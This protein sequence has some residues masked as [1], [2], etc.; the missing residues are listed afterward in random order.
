MNP[1]LR[2]L[3]KLAV[4]SLFVACKSSNPE[5]PSQPGDVQ[6]AMQAPPSGTTGAS[7]TE[8]G[9]TTSGTATPAPTDAQTTSSSAP[10]AT[11]MTDAE[12]AAIASAANKGEIEM[13]ELAT[14][15][16]QNAQVKSFASMMITEHGQAAAKGK[17]IAQKA[18]ITPAENDVS[19]QLKTETETTITSLKSQKGKDFDKAY[20][21]AQVKVH[22]E[23]LSM[24]DDKLM[25]NAKNPELKTH[26]TDM[27]QHVEH[28]LQKAQEIDQKLS[29][30][31]AK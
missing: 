12:I 18:N 13:A 2:N 27:R 21:D 25:P 6:G 29:S 22:K 16:A 17:S 10:A 4:V 31:N 23:V 30:A 5:P 8:V 15:N 9:S 28:H 1:C 19:K 26:L 24:I 3:G 11:P 20:M 14:K 7:P